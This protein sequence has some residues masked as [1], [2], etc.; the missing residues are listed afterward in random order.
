MEEK[1]RQM[2]NY[3]HNYVQGANKE[4]MGNFSYISEFQNEA[5]RKDI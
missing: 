1:L 2:K 4:I 3:I 5:R